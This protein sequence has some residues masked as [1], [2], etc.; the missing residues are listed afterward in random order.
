MGKVLEIREVGDP[1]LKKV[2]KEVDLNR[3]KQSRV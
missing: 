1:I 2:C 3:Y